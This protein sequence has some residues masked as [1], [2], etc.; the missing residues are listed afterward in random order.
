MLLISYRK[1]YCHSFLW[2]QFYFELSEGR[3]P[4]IKT[5]R[6]HLFRKTLSYSTD[7]FTSHFHL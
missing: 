5:A 4:R 2:R 1:N 3:A 7:T 6:K